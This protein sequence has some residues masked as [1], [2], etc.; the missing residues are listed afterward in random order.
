MRFIVSVLPEFE[1]TVLKPV[2]APAANPIPPEM[3][4]TTPPS[5]IEVIVNPLIR[6]PSISSMRS[7]NWLARLRSQTISAVAEHGE[8]Q[9]IGQMLVCEQTFDRFLFA[10]RRQFC[11]LVE[12]R[13]DVYCVCHSQRVVAGVDGDASANYVNLR[14]C[15]NRL[16]SA[17]PLYFLSHK[18]RQQNHLRVR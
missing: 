15:S 17:C 11:E 16:D 1:K 3:M 7:A 4:P 5:T 18:P 10:L 9:A 13:D 6:V 14:T 2:L 8:K 12:K